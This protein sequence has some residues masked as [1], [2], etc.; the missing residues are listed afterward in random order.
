ML[1]FSNIPLMNAVIAKRSFDLISF[2]KLEPVITSSSEKSLIRYGS[3]F[4][5]VSLAHFTP[6]IGEKQH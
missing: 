2:K 6:A 5:S 3:I 1:L 4:L